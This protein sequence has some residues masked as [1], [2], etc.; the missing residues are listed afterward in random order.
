MDTLQF[1]QMVQRNE[2]LERSDQMFKD[3]KV[4]VA[5]L[6]R[7]SELSLPE[8][9]FVLIN[10]QKFLHASVAEFEKKCYT[11]FEKPAD[12]DSGALTLMNSQA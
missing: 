10:L 2:S 9:L 8:V 12:V 7:S 1:L 3:L 5:A 4:N 6:I 11:P